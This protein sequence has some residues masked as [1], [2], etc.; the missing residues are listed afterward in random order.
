[1]WTEVA[2]RS[3]AEGRWV[4]AEDPETAHH[5]PQRASERGGVGR[6]IPLWPAVRS[7]IE[8]RPHGRWHGGR[9]IT[10]HLTV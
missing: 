10:S 9:R 6:G 8:A 7:M 2:V 5:L 3:S 4:V 1:M